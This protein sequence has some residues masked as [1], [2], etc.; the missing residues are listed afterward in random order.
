MRAINLFIIGA[1]LV[2]AFLFI[3]LPAHA[4]T[5]TTTEEFVQKAAVANQFEIATSELAL[6]KASSGEVKNFAQQMVKDHTKAGKDMQAALRTSKTKAA[7]PTGLDA[8]HQAIYDSLSA[9]AGADFD[10][11][12][13]DAQKKAHDEAVSLFESY[14]QVG[15]DNALQEFAKHTLPT[16][17]KHQAHVTKLQAKG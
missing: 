14:A 4:A 9:A 10:R 5:S 17:Q 13:I 3:Q 12:Y 1:L 8:K 15:Q 11:Q 16:L 2:A 7:A 6:Q